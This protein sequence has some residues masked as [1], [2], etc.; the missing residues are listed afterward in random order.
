MYNEAAIF[1]H[2]ILLIQI[3][4]KSITLRYT[5]YIHRILIYTY[6]ICMYVEHSITGLPF[7][8]FF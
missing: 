1:E 3:D 6:T 8:D 5:M 2:I 7:L 4:Y